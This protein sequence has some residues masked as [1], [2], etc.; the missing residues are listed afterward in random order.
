MASIF[1][2]QQLN[3]LDLDSMIF[4]AEIIFANHLAQ[5][6]VLLKPHFFAFKLLIMTRNQAQYFLSQNLASYYLKEAR[7]GKKSLARDV[8][9][10][11]I[12]TQ[13]FRIAPQSWLR[14]IILAS[15]D[16]PYLQKDISDAEFREQN[17]FVAS[18]S[19]LDL[20]FLSD[21]LYY[22]TRTKLAS[23]RMPYFAASYSSHFKFYVKLILVLETYQNPYL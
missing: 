15:L 12:D 13:H 11:Q 8:P 17:L 9:L 10:R 23:H 6:F 20:R 5:L 7:E 14:Y 21:S 1:K 16:C 22:S 3:F 19:W 4:I 2:V 18:Q